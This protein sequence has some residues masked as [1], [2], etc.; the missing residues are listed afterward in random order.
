MSLKN[1]FGV[2]V[3][4]AIDRWVRVLGKSLDP[5]EYPWLKCP[6][7]SPTAVGPQMYNDIAAAEN[8]EQWSSPAA[9]LLTSF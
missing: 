7:G 4:A 3:E 8:L 2:A 5:D 1:I 9:G 6:I